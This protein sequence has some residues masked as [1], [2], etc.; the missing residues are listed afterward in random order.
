[1]IHEI[2][3]IPP[4]WAFILV[5]VPLWCTFQNISK[6]SKQT[7]TALGVAVYLKT[8]EERPYNLADYFLDQFCDIIH[9]VKTARQIFNDRLLYDLAEKTDYYLDTFGEDAKPFIKD[10]F[11]MLAQQLP[12]LRNELLETALNSFLAYDLTKDYKQ[13]TEQQKAPQTEKK[14]SFLPSFSIKECKFY[15]FTE[16][17]GKKNAQ[18]PTEAHTQTEAVHDNDTDI[19]AFLNNEMPDFITD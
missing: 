7:T 10:G 9:Q 19:T 14:P 5:L 8:I 11:N 17:I 6:M 12:T 1:M 18:D 2:L 4:L 13:H 3:H 16:R 15:S